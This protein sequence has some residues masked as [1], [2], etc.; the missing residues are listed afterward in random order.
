MKKTTKTALIA[1]LLIGA[2]G[3]A[4][5][6]P[7]LAKK[8]DSAPVAPKLSAEFIKPA[9]DAQAKI[10]AGDFPA[11]ATALVAAD[12][13][14]KSDDEKYTAATLHLSYEQAKLKASAG[15]NA[16]AFQAGSAALLPAINTLIDNPKTPKEDLARLLVFRAGVLYDSK[17]YAQAVADYVRAR[18]AGSQNPDVDL[19]IMT[20]K[21]ELGDS[22]GAAAELQHQVDLA[23]AAGRKVPEGWYN[24]I[25]SKLY[26]SNK[27]PDAVNWSAKVV[28]AYPTA[29]NW[30]QWV[31][32]YMARL[33]ASVKLD[34]SQRLDLLRLMRAA[35][36]MADQND[37]DEYAQASD[38]L[39]LHAET[40]SVLT[41]GKASGKIPADD[42]MAAMLAASANTGLGLE[43]S[44]EAAE[45]QAKA[46]KS[47]DQSA[48]TADVYLANGNYAKAAELYQDALSKQFDK[49]TPGTTRTRF[50]T[51]DEVNTHLGIAL[52]LAGNKD[53][54][55]AAF[56]KVT[57]SPR[58]EIA[59]FWLTWLDVG[60]A[61]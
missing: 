38:G 49:P 9:S 5:S 18:D 41:E 32:V 15:N 44:I 47:G 3:L 51:T 17:K 2:S 34:R 33:P 54:A 29:P 25:V 23:T 61:S 56:Q 36:V 40:K 55:R 4:T 26:N 24:Y 11:A 21:G 53:G 57:G 59:N 45:K 7:A 30:R 50:V 43:K 16:Q 48:Q 1:A 22:L 58:A 28:A 60:T 8:N 52:A 46:A 14:A 35:K 10:K 37:Y 31:R 19:R 12:A 39:G 42:K 20:G 27:N 6:A 13:A